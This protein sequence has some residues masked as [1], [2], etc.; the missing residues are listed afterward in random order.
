MENIVQLGEPTDI[1]A[2]LVYTP[3][4]HKLSTPKEEE[5]P[6]STLK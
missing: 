1:Y 3:T 4:E 5:T 6:Q 2:D